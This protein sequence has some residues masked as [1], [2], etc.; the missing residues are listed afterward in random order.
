M[1]DVA[2]GNVAG[3]ARHLLLFELELRLTS[4]AHLALENLMVEVLVSPRSFYSMHGRDL[5]SRVIHG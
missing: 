2:F 5:I 1:L 3:I 4:A